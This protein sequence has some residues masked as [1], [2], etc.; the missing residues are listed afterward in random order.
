MADLRRVL[1][2]APRW[3]CVVCEDRGCEFCPD[4]KRADRALAAAPGD[5]SD[6]ETDARRSFSPRTDGHGGA[7]EAEE[8]CPGCG[9]G[10][11]S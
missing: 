8:P 4:T 6:V 11:S 1:G 10:T 2:D 9:G 7:V 5:P 3:L